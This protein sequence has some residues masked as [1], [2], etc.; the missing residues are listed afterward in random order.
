M[1]KQ[2]VA[3]F[4]VDGVLANFEEAFCEAFGNKNR[5][6]Y[7][8]SVRYPDIDPDLIKEW[9]ND[10]ENYRH[11]NPIFGGITFLNQVKARGF[12]IVLVTSR[13]EHLEKV[14]MG[15]LRLYNIP[16]DSLI[17]LGGYHIT[18][19]EFLKNVQ[20]IELFVDDSV[21]ELKQMKSY[22]PQTVCLAWAQP[23][24]DGYFPRAIYDQENMKIMV[25]MGDNNWRWIWSKK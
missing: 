8:L 3:I 22:F 9:V 23:W 14:T 20:G 5:H 2:K 6:L 12:R 15:W 13:P 18:K 1:K 11:L 19:A 21:S 25:N 17:L 10:E 16:Y 24:N 4:D 7:N